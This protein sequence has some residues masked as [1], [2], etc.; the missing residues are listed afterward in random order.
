M[1]DHPVQVQSYQHCLQVSVLRPVG[2]EHGNVMSKRCIVSMQD[3]QSR[4]LTLR[5]HLKP[6]IFSPAECQNCPDLEA[7]AS[8]GKPITEPAPLKPKPAACSKR[9]EQQTQ[10]R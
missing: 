6:D 5:L 3:A 7:E 1:C 8:G 9:A 4:R 10:R 2:E